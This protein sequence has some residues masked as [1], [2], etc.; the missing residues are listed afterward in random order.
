MRRVESRVLAAPRR[1]LPR[2]LWPSPWPRL[3]LPYI[4]PTSPLWPRPLWPRPLWPMAPRPS[5]GPH[6]A[7]LTQVPHLGHISHAPRYHLATTS[8]PPR[9]HPAGTSLAPRTHS[10]APRPRSHHF[11][12]R[13]T[14]T[15]S[16]R[17]CRCRG[18]RPAPRAWCRPRTTLRASRSLRA[19]PSCRAERSSGGAPTCRH[20]SCPHRSSTSD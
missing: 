13:R 5:L 6:D 11:D 19:E 10:L 9:S 7:S 3:Y 8:L 20:T 18:R 12:A 14:R 1:E 16:A 17:S 2:P 4:S 15:A